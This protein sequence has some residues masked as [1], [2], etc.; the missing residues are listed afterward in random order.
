MA[1]CYDFV[2]KRQRWQQLLCQSQD[3]RL[4][5]ADFLAFLVARAIDE[6]ALDAAAGEQRAEDF[7][8]MVAS[9]SGCCA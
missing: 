6:A 9:D 1:Q 5:V 2:A 3:G 8:I 7:R 4:L